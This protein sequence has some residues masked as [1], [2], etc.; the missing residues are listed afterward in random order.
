[1]RNIKENHRKHF[2]TV[3]LPRKATNKIT[4]LKGKKKTKQKDSDGI[5]GGFTKT[6]KII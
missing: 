3:N 5:S 6:R 1:M 4:Q 2:N